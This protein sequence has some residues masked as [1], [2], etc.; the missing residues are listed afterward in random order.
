MTDLLISNSDDIFLVMSNKEFKGIVRRKDLL[1]AIKEDKTDLTLK[2][3]LRTD[4]DTVKPTDNLSKILPMI[5]KHGQS[6][7]P[8]LDGKEPKGIISLDSIQRYMA[9]QGAL[10]Y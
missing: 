10:G 4:F 1:S 9:V 6:T 5:R 3:L 8:V 7:F 2:D